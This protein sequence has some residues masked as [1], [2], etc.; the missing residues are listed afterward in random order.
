MEGVCFILAGDTEDVGR[1]TLWQIVGCS[2]SGS[3]PGFHSMTCLFSLGHTL[4]HLPSSQVVPLE[5]ADRE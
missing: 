1:L 2:V 4:L 3:R 5:R